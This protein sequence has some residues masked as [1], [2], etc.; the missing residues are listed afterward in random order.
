M[1]LQINKM[2][3]PDI[4]GVE[5]VVSDYANYLKKYDDITV[6]CINKYFSLKT[7]IEIRDDVTIYR[8]AS[9]GTFMSM[10]IS[11]VFFYHMFLLS[12]KAN[13][14]HI[15]EPFPLASLGYFLIPKKKKIF[16]TWHSD[17]IKQKSIKVF[18]EFFQ[19]KLCRKAD[20]IIVTS[21]N[22]KT[23]SYILKKYKDKLIT[24]PLAISPEEYT[25]TI[26][27]NLDINNLPKNYVLF[28]GRFSYYKGIFTLLDAIEDINEDIPFVIVGNGDLSNQIYE[29]ILKSSKNIYFINRYVSDKEKKCLLKYSKFMV[30]PS[31]LPS[32]A[33]GIIQ[34]ESMIYGKPVINTNLDTGVPW[35][36][37]HNVSGLTSEVSNV[38]SLSSNIK[39]L[40]FDEVL[41][42][43]L[44]RGAIDRINKYF[45][46][47]KI[48]KKLYNL[49]FED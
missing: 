41:Y 15:H 26:N 25:N 29:R 36:S 19:K 48:N 37:K 49:Y 14:I 8:C 28:L 34:L 16:L 24:I 11:F 12:R 42:K 4:G 6:L 46:S 17:I 1:I 32:E 7:K 10:P 45:T 30:F 40:Y 21:E 22:M 9:L 27:C 31:I 35:V 39:K 47:N 23:F 5:T 3:T 33:F 20:K 38:Q 18:F 43:R 44:S 2:Y 13:Y